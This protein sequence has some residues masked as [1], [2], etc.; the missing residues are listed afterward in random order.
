MDKARWWMVF[1][2]LMALPM[3]ANA[4]E[5]ATPPLQT[6][7]QLPQDSSGG[8]SIGGMGGANIGGLIETPGA[9]FGLG[10]M[11]AG[12]AASPR[13]AAGGF[14]DAWPKP[15]EYWIGVECTR[16]D[17][18]LRAHLQLPEGQG[19]VVRSVVPDSPAAKAGL[20]EHD[21]LLQAGDK[22]LGSLDDLIDAVQAAKEQKLSLEFVR[23]GKRQKIEVTPVKRPS[24]QMLPGFG[25]GTWIPAPGNPDFEAFR[26]W[27]EKMQPGQPLRFRFFQPGFVAPPGF[28]GQFG[29]GGSLPE[30]LSIA[31]TKTGNE[32]AR[33]SVKKDGQTWE[34]TEK[35][36]DK[37]PPDVRPHVERMLGRG[38]AIDMDF[39]W[40]V[41]PP[42]FG[43]EPKEP[44]WPGR[45]R[46]D[47][48]KQL[49]RHQQEMEK[50]QQQIDDLKKSLEKLGPGTPPKEPKKHTT[51][52]PPE[53]NV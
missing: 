39:P 23:E 50:L 15:S 3:V 5:Q 34:V 10:G 35:E 18:T 7:F 38:G 1:G 30:G 48:Q 27:F 17:P 31:I 51:K 12:G 45:I 41:G 22:K 42:W 32:P 11:G 36:L 37:L 9:E 14:S 19:L 43:A 25:W 44:K 13:D 16:V 8:A 26:K 6:P 33:I 49:E 52:K 29:W 24:E 21:I 47:L 2:V 46:Q 20:R 28:G 53:E 40:E 4:A